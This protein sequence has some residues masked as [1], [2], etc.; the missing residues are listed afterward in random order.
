[1]LLAIFPNM[2]TN[3]FFLHKNSLCSQKWP[4]YFISH[5]L[6]LKTLFYIA[7]LIN[8]FLKLKFYLM[9]FSVLPTLEARRGSQI[10]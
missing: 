7:Y 8:H 9:H 2:K 5:F 1:M 4:N 10:P 6:K 3:I